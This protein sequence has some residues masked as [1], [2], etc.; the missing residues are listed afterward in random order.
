MQLQHILEDRRRLMRL[1]LASYHP[2]EQPFLVRAFRPLV[3]PFLVRAFH[4]LVQPF[5]V[6]AFRPLVQQQ[7]LPFQAP[8]FHP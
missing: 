3:Q 4:P 1:A 7:V 6:R 5:L 8:A 2:L